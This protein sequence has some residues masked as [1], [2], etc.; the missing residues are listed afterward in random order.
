MKDSRIF[1]GVSKARS[2]FQDCHTVQNLSRHS[3]IRVPKDQ[4]AIRNFSL[5]EKCPS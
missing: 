1:H 4:L 2:K 5:K 3:L